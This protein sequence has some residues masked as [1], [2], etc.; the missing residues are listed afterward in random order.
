MAATPS[1]RDGS[2]T[3]QADA[4]DCAAGDAPHRL[5][6]VGYLRGP[7]P[8][9]LDCD[10]PLRVLCRGCDLE[11]RWAC[12]GHRESKCKPC[13]ARYRRRVQRV[14]HSGTSRAEGWQYLLTLTAPG[15]RRHR[16]P[17]GDWCPC[18]PEGGVDLARWNASH[19]ARWNRFRTAIRRDH[20][21]LQFFRGVEVQERGALHD[22]A[23]V[24]SPR[25]LAKRRL[26]ELALAAGF[27][28][29]LDLAPAP[30]GSKRV[31]YYVS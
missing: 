19:S 22:H 29:S 31:A 15:A 17:S 2:D 26:R 24:W 21:E 18:T 27:G 1:V 7:R 6:V 25:P 12:S 3:G 16:M 28:H 5:F 4:P 11:T 30:P 8:A 20:P 13:S 10:R 14:A 23:M 9:W